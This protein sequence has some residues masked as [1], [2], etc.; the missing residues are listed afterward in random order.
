MTTEIEAAEKITND[1]RVRNRRP[2]FLDTIGSLFLQ[3]SCRLSARSQTT[4]FGRTRTNGS[5]RVA[6]LLRG[7]DGTLRNPS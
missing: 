1:L 6:S 4:I 7:T 3:P 2:G 5:A